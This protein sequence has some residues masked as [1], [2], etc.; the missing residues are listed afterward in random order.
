MLTGRSA[1]VNLRTVERDDEQRDLLVA[2][3]SSGR[4][5]RP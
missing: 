1:L 4:F 3:D 5:F 2:L